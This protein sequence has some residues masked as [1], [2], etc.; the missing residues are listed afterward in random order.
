MTR[1]VSGCRWFL[2]NALLVCAPAALAAQS[3]REGEADRV[4]WTVAPY[5]LIPTMSGDLT[6]GNQTIGVDAGPGDIFDKLQFGAMLYVQVRK[7]AWGGAVDGLYMNLEQ[8][9]KQANATAGAKQGMVD[10]SAFRRLT[11]AIDVLL[12]ARVNIMESSLDLPT[13]GVS[14][15]DTKTWV[16]PI[17]G[18]LLH[19][20]L[21]ASKWTV[22][23]R[24][25]IGGFGLGS[26]FAYQLYPQLGFR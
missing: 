16:D 1:L 25:D 26:S 21:G 19:Q 23:M 22:G 17:V 24:A 11:P 20:Q 14:V 15:S 3:P 9:A 5:F 10:M 13:P 4:E 2:L 6:V 12:G 8:D 18:V 7:G